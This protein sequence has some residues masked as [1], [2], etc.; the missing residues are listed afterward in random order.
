MS[1]K[2]SLEQA[3]AREESLLFKLDEARAQTL[4]RLNEFKRELASAKSICSES[5]L[6]CRSDM[7]DK[8]RL[9]LSLF[10]GRDDVYARR[11][12]NRKKGTSGYSPHCLNEWARGLCAKPKGKCSGCRHKAYVPLDEKQLRLICEGMSSQACIRCSLMK[13]VGFWLSIWTAGSG[14]GMSRP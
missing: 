8:I 11:W 4:S 1:D 14:A 6:N 7:A 10:K 13:P 12:E 2:K 9:F 3:I 5:G